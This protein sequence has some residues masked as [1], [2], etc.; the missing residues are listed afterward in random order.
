MSDYHQP[1]DRLSKDILQSIKVPLV[2]FLTGKEPQEVVPL[3][4]EFQQIQSKAADLLFMARFEDFE[5]IFHIEMQ[6]DNHPQMLYR[7]LGYFNEIV[8]QYEMF[9]VQ[10]VLYFGRNPMNMRNQ[11][12]NGGENKV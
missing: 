4:I 3:N 7:M 11:L 6:T 1:Y 2:R 5:K 9:P 10:T 12:V 8:R